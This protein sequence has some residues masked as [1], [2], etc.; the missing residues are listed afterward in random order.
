MAEVTKPTGLE[1]VPGSDATASSR[2]RERKRPGAG[3]HAS[4]KK[5]SLMKRNIT[6]G[7]PDATTIAPPPEDIARVRR[8]LR[9]ALCSFFAIHNPSQNNPKSLDHIVKFYTTF[10]S[11]DALNKRL[12]DK[13]GQDLTSVAPA[14]APAPAPAAKTNATQPS[15]TP[16]VPTAAPAAARPETKYQPPTAAPAVPQP[17]SPKTRSMERAAMFE[18]TWVSDIPSASAEVKALAPIKGLS[19]LTNRLSSAGFVLVASG[20]NAGR[21][22]AYFYVMSAQNQATLVLFELQSAMGSG[23]TMNKF[24]L[25]YKYREKVEAEAALARFRTAVGAATAP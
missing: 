10:D 21:V 9:A 14:T 7:S 18:S 25:E 8:E 4:P 17:M 13:Y 20:S 24:T 22:K 19:N 5:N 6:A 3:K 11:T 23:E 15:P 12:R 1:L 2:R 16:A